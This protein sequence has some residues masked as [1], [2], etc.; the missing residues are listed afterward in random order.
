MI[1]AAFANSGSMRLF[2]KFSGET[3]LRTK[4]PLGAKLYQTLEEHI[5]TSRIV[6]DFAFREGA[7]S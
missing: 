4:Q 5:K 7:F 6:L 2:A 1:S 3:A